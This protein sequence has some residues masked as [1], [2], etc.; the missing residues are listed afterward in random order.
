M[1]LISLLQWSISQ[2]GRFLGRACRTADMSVSFRVLAC[3]ISRHSAHDRRQSGLIF[4][5]QGKDWDKATNACKH[6]GNGQFNNMLKSRQLNNSNRHTTQGVS[7]GISHSP[8]KTF[9]TCN[10][11]DITQNTYFWIVFTV[12]PCILINQV[13]LFIQ[14]MHNYTA[15][16]ECQ[17]LHYIYNKMLLHVSVSKP[18]S[19]SYDLCFAKVIIIKIIS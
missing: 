5:R 16:K 14:L 13:F 19:G 3:L 8:E 1:Q 2:T 7:G 10:Y 9:L 6:S 15:L 17:N 12:V 18:S 4:N 11:I